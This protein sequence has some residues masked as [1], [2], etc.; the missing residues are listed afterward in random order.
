MW[1]RAENLLNEK[2]I[3]SFQIIASKAIFTNQNAEENAL[4]PVKLFKRYREHAYDQLYKTVKSILKS[5]L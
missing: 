4:M 5:V 2:S 3:L 1:K